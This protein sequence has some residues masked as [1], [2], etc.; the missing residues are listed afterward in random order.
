MVQVMVATESQQTLAIPRL[1]LPELPVGNRIE[2]VLRHDGDCATLRLLYERRDRIAL[3]RQKANNIIFG[4]LARQYCGTTEE[5]TAAVKLMSY[6]F[7]WI[8]RTLRA[9]I[10]Q[11]AQQFVH[12]DYQ[13]AFG[14]GISIETAANLFLM[15]FS[16]RQKRSDKSKRNAYE[17]RL[18]YFMAMQVLQ[19][20]LRDDP[21]H[22]EI[23]MKAIEDRVIH[24]RSVPPLDE[25]GVVKRFFDGHELTTGR[26][27]DETVHVTMSS[28]ESGQRFI[29]RTAGTLP[30]L[31]T[32]RFRALATTV[33]YRERDIPVWIK[34]RVKSLLSR[35]MKWCIKSRSARTYTPDLLGVRFIVPGDDFADVSSWLQAQLGVIMGGVTARARPAVHP[36]GSKKGT[37]SSP[38]ASRMFRAAR[39]HVTMGSQLAE[40]Q[41]M[42][43]ALAANV[44]FSI[45]EENDRRF[46][47]RRWQAFQ[48]TLRPRP[49]YPHEWN[50][51][52]VR[53]KNHR[54]M[55]KRLHRDLGMDTT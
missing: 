5:V 36:G 10:K 48:H 9:E 44:M 1:L 21:D 26:W 34:I 31:P 28:P 20:V 4:P 46:G 8:V 41:V 17:A 25:V 7:R 14:S 2:Q 32:Y 3:N 24:N 16:S 42:P 38:F 30:G 23:I 29:R 6:L 12:P 18:M 33:R 53:Q 15:A 37:S 19:I 52:F 55:I 40:V 49:L 51:T 43:L 47:W 13:D 50:N 54:W 35:W 22:R 11:S 27:S 39:V 45:E